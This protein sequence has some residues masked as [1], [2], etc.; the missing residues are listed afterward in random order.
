MRRKL[1]ERIGEIN[2]YT[3]EFVG[4]AA[5][6]STGKINRALFL[7]VKDGNEIV[8]DHLWVSTKLL[9]VFLKAGDRVRFMAEVSSYKKKKVNSRSW[10][11]IVTDYNFK[12]I[13]N[14]EVI[15]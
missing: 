5:N 2:E 11:K 8:T 13:E 14:L 3:A 4:Y 9:D 6:K 10:T 7:N 1:M 15:G 12:E